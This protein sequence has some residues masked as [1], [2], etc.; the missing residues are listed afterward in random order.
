MADRGHFCTCL[1]RLYH[2]LF[3]N[4]GGVSRKT[5]GNK[6]CYLKNGYGFGRDGSGKIRGNSES[7]GTARGVNCL[8]FTKKRLNFWIIPEVNSQKKASKKPGTRPLLCAG[9]AGRWRRGHFAR[10]SEV[11]IMLF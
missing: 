11:E 5:P 7:G 9:G 4:G 8:I 10:G 6:G 1:L 2:N 3:R